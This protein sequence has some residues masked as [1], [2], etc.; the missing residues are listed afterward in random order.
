MAKEQPD[1]KD[2]RVIDH[3][4]N[5]ENHKAHYCF[6]NDETG[7]MTFQ[8]KDEEQSYVVAVYGPKMWTSCVLATQPVSKPFDDNGR[9][10]KGEYRLPSRGRMPGYPHV[11]HDDDI[12]F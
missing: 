1:L 3:L 9:P 11:I 10:K 8:F 12:P 4:G 6:V 7:T 2:W 5:T